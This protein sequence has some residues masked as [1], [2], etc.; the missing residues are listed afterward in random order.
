MKRTL[1]TLAALVALAL[2]ATTASAWGPS[3]PYTKLADGNITMHGAGAPLGATVSNSG[4]TL[5]VHHWR[6][7]SVYTW[8]PLYGYTKVD[9]GARVT[10]VFAMWGAWWKTVNGNP[11]QTGSWI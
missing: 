9:D 3:P 1:F 5:T 11:N 8:D 7:P 4:T 2:I 6:W 10:Y